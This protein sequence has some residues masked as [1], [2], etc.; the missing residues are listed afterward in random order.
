MPIEPCSEETHSRDDNRYCGD[1]GKCLYDP[2]QEEITAHF[3]ARRNETAML[4]AK[5][6]T[7]LGSDPKN[8][9]MLS[10]ESRRKKSL[11]RWSRWLAWV[12]CENNA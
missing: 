5:V 12:E 9:K 3:N 4:V 1:C 6:Q 10:L 11:D 7:D 8:K 2:A